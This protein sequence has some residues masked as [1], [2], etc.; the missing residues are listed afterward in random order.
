MYL[1]LG[2][3]LNQNTLRLAHNNGLGAL[4]TPVET[5]E[6]APANLNILDLQ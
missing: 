5:W 1:T 3:S 4:I 6:L 2:S